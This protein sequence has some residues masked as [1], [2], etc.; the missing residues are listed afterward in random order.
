VKTGQVV[1]INVG[2]PR[3]IKMRG[4]TVSTSIWKFPVTGRIAVRRYNL[5]GDQQSDLT[6]HG[7]PYQAIYQY[8]REHYP[9]WA[10]QLPETSLPDGAFG[11]NLTT[12]GLTEQ[13]VHIGDQFQIG[14]A[15]V[16]A[17]QPRPSD[18]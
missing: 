4:G 1:S 5:E 16:Q 7:G 10:E 11:E 8:A 17:T 6:V 14:S 2:R 15:V 18:C 9:Y 13:S 12:E 3:E